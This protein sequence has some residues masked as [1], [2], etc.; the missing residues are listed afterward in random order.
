MNRSS[1]PSR[2]RKAAFTEG[3]WHIERGLYGKPDEITI[4]GKPGRNDTC[5]FVATLGNAQGRDD[6]NAALILAAPDLLEA[7]ESL[8]KRL[9]ECMTAPISAAEAYDSFYQEIAAEA[10]KKARNANGK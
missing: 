3:P 7:L 4:W 8:D 5:E 2:S 6:R 10:I 1:T 9:R